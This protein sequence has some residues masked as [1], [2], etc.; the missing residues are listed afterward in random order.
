MPTPSEPE[1]D[2][3]CTTSNGLTG[4]QTSVPGPSDTVALSTGFVS[5]VTWANTYPMDE[6]PYTASSVPPPDIM[7]APPSIMDTTPYGGAA[8]DTPPVGQDGAGDDF[9]I[10][11]RDVIAALEQS[12]IGTSRTTTVVNTN[13]VFNTN[14]D[15]DIT[16][17]VDIDND[18]THMDDHE[19]QM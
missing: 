19:M 12:S 9:S 3:P 13:A 14:S 18:Q 16:D 8:P 11:Y 6:G 10:S 2:G 7:E 5:P 1:V 15:L 17:S 4:S